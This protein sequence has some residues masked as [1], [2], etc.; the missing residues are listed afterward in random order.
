M[1]VVVRDIKDDI[2][3]SC[4]TNVVAHYEEY[5]AGEL[6]IRRKVERGRVSVPGELSVSPRPGVENPRRGSRS[7]C[8]LKNARERIL[9][10]DIRFIP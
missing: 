3:R 2:G 7:P 1:K 9:S 10:R 8:R 4:D 5:G 6:E